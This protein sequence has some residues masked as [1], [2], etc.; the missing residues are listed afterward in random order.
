MGSQCYLPPG[1]GDI[2]AFTLSEAGT[3]LAIPEGCKAALTWVNDFVFLFLYSTWTKLPPFNFT[4]SAHRCALF[5]S[6]ISVAGNLKVTVVPSNLLISITAPDSGWLTSC[7]SRLQIQRW[8]VLLV[9]GW[10]D[11]I[12]KYVNGYGLASL[13]LYPNIGWVPYRGNPFE[14][15]FQTYHANSWDP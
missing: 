2:L 8:L 9:R 6:M 15:P 7:W 10:C 13:K 14:F 11:V 12:C 3:R 1:S 5:T 4:L